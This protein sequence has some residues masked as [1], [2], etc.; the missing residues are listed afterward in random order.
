M[1]NRIL[2]GGVIVRVDETRYSPA[3]VPITRLILDHRSVQQEADLP[4]EARCRLPVMICGQALQPL[5]QSLSPGHGIR[6]RGFLARADHRRGES[7][8]V[9]HATEI[10]PLHT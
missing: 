10:E 5:L 1:D 6:V 3:G 9:L 4:R 2:L 8:L 7:Q